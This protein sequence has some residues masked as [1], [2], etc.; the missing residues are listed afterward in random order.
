MKNRLFRQFVAIAALSSFATFLSVCSAV[1]KCPTTFTEGADAAA[2][3]RLAIPFGRRARRGK[4]RH[5]TPQAG[6]PLRF[7]TTGALRGRPAKTR[8]RWTAR[9]TEKVPPA[10]AAAISMAASAG[11]AK[12]SRFRKLPTQ[13]RVF[14]QFDGVFMDSDVWLNGH[15]LGNHPYGYTGFQY[16]LTQY[17]KRDG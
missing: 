4:K 17:L 1:A 6:E 16:D 9:S 8:R 12:R 5:S 7:R 11:I 14:V 2:R 3:F 13:S 10:S 15:H